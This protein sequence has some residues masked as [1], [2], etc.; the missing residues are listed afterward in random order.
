MRNVLLI[1]KKKEDTDITGSSNVKTKGAISQGILR[2]TSS[3]KPRDPKDY[4]QPSKEKHGLD[5]LG[6]LGGSVALRTP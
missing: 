5:S 3:N 2:I 1:E 6:A 4:Q